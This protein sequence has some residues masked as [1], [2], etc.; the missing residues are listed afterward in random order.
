MQSEKH[1]FF[2]QVFMLI[3]KDALIE[4]R[5]KHAL[6][7]LLLFSVSTVM[8]IYFSLLYNGN[9]LSQI[10]P[11]VWSILL[12]LTVLFSAVNAVANSFFREREENLTY[13]HFL[14]S[15]VVFIVAKIIY[16]IFFSLLLTVVSAL[17]FSL[18][19]SN[20]VQNPVLFFEIMLLGAVSYAILFTLMSGI[21][22]KARSDNTLVAVL[23]FP[24]LIPM[25]IFITKIT[26][27]ALGAIEMQELANK[28]LLLLLAL[29]VVQLILA[30]ILFPYIWKE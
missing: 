6:G 29:N 16:N 27:A 2:S 30:G 20:P 22:L 4:M 19:I 18:T 14:F 21:A 17:I 9:A 23:G 7:G 24:I 13:Y 12:W 15:P 11:A 1:S 10:T 3:K 28:N 5:N 8:I 26:S 25:L